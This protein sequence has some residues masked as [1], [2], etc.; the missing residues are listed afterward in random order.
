MMP[1]NE[2]VLYRA[3]DK[4]ELRL[5]PWKGEAIALLSLSD[6][7][8][9]E[10]MGQI[11]G[12][13]DR[14][15]LCYSELAQHT[16]IP[17]P[18]TTLE[19]RATIAEVPA[20]SIDVAAH[21][22][23][24][25]TGIEIGSEYF[26]SFYE[27]VR[28]R[29]VFDQIPFYELGRNFWFYETK[30]NRHEGLTTGFAIANRFAVMVR[31]GVRGAPFNGS[32]PFELFKKSILV[33]LYK[34]YQKDPRADFESSILKAAPFASSGNWGVGDL[35]AALFHRILEV[36]GWEAYCRFWQRLLDRPDI[37]S[38]QEIAAQLL[39]AYQEATGKDG[40]AL[41]KAGRAP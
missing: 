30:V 26:T 5:F 36:D 24:R 2:S 25:H 39:G 3:F 37:Q 9:P 7:L 35:C 31:I 10:T 27:G 22:Y 40:R 15:F 28:E 4:S 38:D 14:A 32:M 34:D 17:L 12:T 16:P 13:L 1:P 41:L 6:D 11:V 20:G 19:G 8:D 21:A 18:E 23:L 29:Q 33:D